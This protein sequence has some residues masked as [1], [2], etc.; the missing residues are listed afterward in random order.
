MLLG[1]TEISTST[2]TCTALSIP[3][4]KI[5]INIRINE[6]DNNLN[7]FRNTIYNTKSTAFNDY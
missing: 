3:L 7:T 4:D 6:L 2:A 5:N 1:E